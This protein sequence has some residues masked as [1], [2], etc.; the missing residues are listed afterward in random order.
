MKLEAQLLVLP[1]LVFPSISFLFVLL[2]LLIFG[3]E[4]V[5]SFFHN[6]VLYQVMDTVRV[7]SLQSGQLFGVSITSNRLKK[8]ENAPWLVNRYVNM[9]L[10]QKFI[11]HR[12]YKLENMPSSV[13][14]IQEFFFQSSLSLSLRSLSM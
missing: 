1:L 13:S 7:G 2:R 5:T 4:D 10:F 8:G 14:S 11:R 9:W 3:D 6:L 12:P